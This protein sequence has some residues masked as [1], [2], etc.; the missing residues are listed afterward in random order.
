MRN[1]LQLLGLTI[2]SVFLISCQSKEKKAAELIKNELSKTLYDFDSYQP[3]ETIV[4]EAKMTRYNDTACWNQANLTAY[5]FERF[6]NLTIKANAVQEKM[7]LWGKPTSYSSRYSDN[8]YYK[9][10]KEYD[11]IIDEQVIALRIF[12]QCAS[13]LKEKIDNL[14]TAKVI[15]W[16]V[17]HRFRC[18]TKG[19][20]SDIADYRYI[21]DKDF[22]TIILNDSDKDRSKAIRDILEDTEKDDSQSLFM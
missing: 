13:N 9:Y 21:I 3:I 2:I 17:N 18:K 6:M 16:E 11:E 19:G 8:N 4:S 5:A 10:K 22:K 20:Y 1:A 12:A 7:N 14:D 15:G